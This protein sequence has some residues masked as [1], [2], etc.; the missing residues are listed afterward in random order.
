MNASFDDDE[1]CFV[2]T[3]VPNDQNQ[4]ITFYEKMIHFIR[5]R[6][7]ENILIGGDFNCL[8][9]ALEEFGGKDVKTKKA[10]IRSIEEL[11]N[12]FIVWLILG[13]IYQN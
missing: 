6:Q 1:F 8:L 3:Y 12:N 13:D 9:S 2:N 5:C 10:V 11:C 7:A 4:Q